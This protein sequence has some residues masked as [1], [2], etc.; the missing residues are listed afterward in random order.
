VGVML[1]FQTII[2]F[3]PDFGAVMS[4][5]ILTVGLLFLGG[6]RLNQLAV[7]V[8][9][10]LPAIYILLASSPYR[11]KR[12]TCFL[13]PWR[14]SQGCGFQLIQSFIALGNGGITGLGI[15]GSR[16][17]LFFLPEVHTDFI[18]SM[19][20]EEMGFIGAIVV[21]GLF[22][23]LVVKGVR[24]A[25]DTDDSFSYYLALGLTM[26]IG[27]QVIIN[28]AVSTGLMPT[29]GLPL[30]FISYGGSALL[31]NMIAIGILLN[32]SGRNDKNKM[33]RRTY[34]DISAGSASQRRGR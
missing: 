31:I 6:A 9:L 10:S 26:M 25:M 32:I 27:S 7:L 21:L 23:W 20:G 29:K 22:I 28:I 14:D 13:D 33:E 17:K 24:V 16:Q 18:F 2:I 8:L 12:I 4:L 5:G 34:S 1:M 3:Q 19:I 30:P 11:W 15:G